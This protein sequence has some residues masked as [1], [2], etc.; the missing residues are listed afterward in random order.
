MKVEELLP[1]KYRNEASKYE[2]GTETMDV[3]F[4]SGKA[5]YHSFITHG[6]VLDEKGFK[7]SKSLG[8]VVDPSIVIEGG[9]NSKDLAF[10]ADVLRLWVSSVDYTGDV[11]IGT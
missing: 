4:D 9:K 1:E 3:W 10:G 11:M 7:M 5:L 6:F 2:K 8:N